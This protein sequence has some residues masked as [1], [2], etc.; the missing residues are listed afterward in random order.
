[1]RGFFLYILLIAAPAA[2]AAEEY[3]CVNQKGDVETLSFSQNS[4]NKLA[5]FA[6]AESAQDVVGKPMDIGGL[7]ADS[8]NCEDMN[9]F[10]GSNVKS[11]QVFLC[12]EEIIAPNA[13]FGQV[14][15]SKGGLDWIINTFLPEELGYTC[16][17]Q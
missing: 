6:I 4:E 13:I 15:V 9:K 12:D 16:E 17:K 1:M 10:L 5:N 14:I 2:V 8:P 11:D 7:L 3:I